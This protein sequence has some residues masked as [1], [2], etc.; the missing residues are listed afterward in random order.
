MSGDKQF[1]EVRNEFYKEATVII[2]VFDTIM[3]ASFDQLDM[4]L[5][6]ANANGAH[7]CTLMLVANKKGQQGR[8]DVTIEEAQ[9]WARSRSFQ[10]FEVSAADDT[11]FHDLRRLILNN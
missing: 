11:G 2:L 10:Y 1:L 5:R 9:A 8:R 3:R 4:W 7:R 6:E